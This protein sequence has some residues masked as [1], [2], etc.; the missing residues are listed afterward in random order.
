MTCCLP[1]YFYYSYA[2]MIKHFNVRVGLY[3]KTKMFTGPYYVLNCISGNWWDWQSVHWQ[4]NYQFPP[5]SYQYIHVHWT[6]IPHNIL[7]WYGQIENVFG[8]V[9]MIPDDTWYQ[10]LTVNWLNYQSTF[11][12][13]LISKFNKKA[14]PIKTTSIWYRYW[15]PIWP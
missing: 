1:V 3:I 12:Y 2:M 10:Y 5:P 13:W 15:Y 11:I 7:I 8:R 9:R 6:Q 14:I 4:S